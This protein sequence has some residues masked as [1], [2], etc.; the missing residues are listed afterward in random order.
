MKAETRE[1]HLLI[2]NA[3]HRLEEALGTQGVRVTETSVTSNGGGDLPRP[4][5]MPQNPLIE[6]VT[7]TKREA[8]APTTGRDAGRFA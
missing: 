6:A 8:D 1:A 7:E 4:H 3:Q 5:F 2:A